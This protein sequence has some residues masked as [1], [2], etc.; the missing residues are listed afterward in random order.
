MVDDGLDEL[1]RRGPN[2]RGKAA[3]GVEEAGG[4]GPAAGGVWHHIN[5]GIV[6]LVKEELGQALEG[7]GVP[8]VAP[9]VDLEDVGL[10]RPEVISEIEEGVAVLV[11]LN[12]NPEALEAASVR[13]AFLKSIPEGSQGQEAEAQG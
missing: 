10:H 13:D 5:A 6:Q 4:R 2:G 9:F 8:G 1:G 3:P 11:F 7:G 12:G